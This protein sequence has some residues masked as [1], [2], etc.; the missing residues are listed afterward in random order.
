MLGAGRGSRSPE[1]LRPRGGG[2]RHPYAPSS[3][4]RSCS[5]CSRS[6][7]W[8]RDWTT[9]WAPDFGEEDLRSRLAGDAVRRS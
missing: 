1:L 4:S 5:P 3:R 7:L 2:V 9:R 6:T 8:A